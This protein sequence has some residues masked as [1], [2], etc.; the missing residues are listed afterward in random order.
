[1]L[2]R[3]LFLTV[4][5]AGLP[6]AAV[7]GQGRLSGDEVLPPEDSLRM[8]HVRPGFRV[9]LFASEPLVVN[10]LAIDFDSRGRAYV[11]EARQ[12]P[13]KATNGPGR[14]RILILE[15]TDGDFRADR[16]KVFAE[17]LN[18]ASGLAVGYGGVFVGQA[19][20]LLFLED[21]N[22][23]DRA[24]RR[25]VLLD[26]WVFEDTHETLNSFVIGPDGWLYGTHGIMHES[27]VRGRRFNA[28]VWRYH[29]K[30]DRFEVV[31]EGTN[32][33]WGLDFNRSGDWFVSTSVIPHLFHIAPGGFHRH[34]LIR[35]WTNP[36]AYGEIWP[37]VDHRHFPPRYSGWELVR[38][39]MS[40]STRKNIA[41]DDVL[42]YGGGHAHSGL[43]I[44]STDLWPEELRGGAIVG[45][46]HGRRLNVDRIRPYR[47][48]YI[49]THQ[50]DLLWSDDPFFRPV[51]LKFG[52]RGALYVLDWYDRQICHNTDPSVWDR[53]FG[54]IYVVVPENL[55]PERDAGERGGCV[56]ALASPDTWRW[57]Q[58][59][60]RVA[61]RGLRKSDVAELRRWMESGDERRRLRALWALYVAGRLGVEELVQF[62]SSSNDAV[63]AAATRL[64][65]DHADRLGD[66]ELGQLAALATSDRA[67]NRRE[68]ASLLIRAPSGRGRDRLLHL[69][70]K[71]GEDADDPEIPA[72]LWVAYERD[73]LKRWSERRPWLI[74]HAGEPV[75]R[76]RIV[77]WTVRRLCEEQGAEWTEQ[78]LRFLKDL[79][80]PAATR[81][82]V[83]A[84]LEALAGRRPALRPVWSAV[85]PELYARLDDQEGRLLLDR[86]GTV[87]G[88]ADAERRLIEAVRSVQLPEA[89]RVS[90]VRTLAHGSLRESARALVAVVADQ[91]APLDLR[92]AA[93][94]SLTK[95]LDQTV[96]RDLLKHW[97][98]FH[99]ELRHDLLRFF[100]AN[101]VGA[102][103]L[104]RAV[105]R[106]AVPREDVP[107]GVVRRMLMIGDPTLRELVREAWGAVR[108]S[109]TLEARRR[110]ARLGAAVSRLPGNRRRGE[111]LFQTHCAGCHRFRNIGVQ[112]GP[113]LGGAN[114]KDP[115][116][117]VFN[118]GDPNRVVGTPYFTAL[119][120]DRA[121]R[122]Y[123][124][125]LLRRTDAYIELLM[126][127]GE[128]VRLGRAEV[129][130][131]RI[132][133]QSLM[134]EDVSDQMSEQEFAD[135]VAFLM[136]DLCLTEGLVY[137][138]ILSDRPL[139]ATHPI[140]TS[141]DPLGYDSSG[142]RPFRLGPG[143]R[144]VLTLADI[145]KDRRP[146]EAAFFVLFRVR[147]P[148]QFPTHLYLDARKG[149]VVWLNG[150]EVYRSERI[151]APVEVPVRLRAGENL[152]LI[153]LS[154]LSR[155]P[156]APAAAGECSLMAR[157]Y[158]PDF[159]LELVPVAAN[160]GSGAR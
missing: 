66:A 138:P 124:G 147:S 20:Q 25:T 71:N 44:C 91:A 136:E 63:G 116:Y 29:P 133:E 46:L 21:T 139:A 156:N 79:D 73:L 26:G 135:L 134:P 144:L 27:T 150:E 59:L 148:K 75:V 145:Q 16:V 56:A 142:W 88:D 115:Y 102:R 30:W 119:A 32:N 84:A 47:S 131:V 111:K 97:S 3:V 52:P 137:G 87:C 2:K 110:V 157:I 93:L 15:D 58:A 76:E 42:A 86:L 74:A 78:A 1:M 64:L 123:R 35:W 128:K 67:R 89:R 143:G 104:L 82:G 151:V 53:Q 6:F 51:H 22:G 55:P 50:P 108:S 101:R 13:V 117:L 118:I 60:R 9:Q 62:A 41:G 92:K 83:E 31:A 10:P 160:A 153:K 38:Y 33:P 80:D 81:R 132:M 96:A 127:K 61:H 8:M 18:L 122:I 45:N 103:E 72:L 70:M 154:N 69:L 43:A 120:A 48:G 109:S 141:P 85:R 106:G 54:R 4:L 129:E 39:P 5:A 11:L 140:E 107:E 105:K 121:G 114:L 90:A 34:G 65:G 14:D 19:P 12:Y 95:R 159:E 125:L 37:I 99:D 100:S 158:D 24:D 77:G 28:A 68:L 36:H 130:S 113:D 57:R 146:P 7:R 40:A 126:E 17:G 152:L 112:V 98:A 149:A 23:D 94:E 49:A 155:L